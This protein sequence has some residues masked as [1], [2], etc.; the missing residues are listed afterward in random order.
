M[1]GAIPIPG[2]DATAVTAVQVKLISDLAAV[3][4]RRIDKDLVLF[5]LGEAAR[6]HVEGLRAL[7]A[8][9]GE[10]GRLDPGRAGRDG[11]PSSG[12]GRD[13]RGRHDLRRRAGPR[14]PS[15]SAT[16]RSA[17]TSCARCSTTRRRRTADDH[18]NR[19]AS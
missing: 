10:G 9:G 18:D 11:R 2:A 15:S 16:A 4:G 12:L 8:R 3:F 19:G 7:G 13:R 1:A 6:R 14:S 5:I 17:A